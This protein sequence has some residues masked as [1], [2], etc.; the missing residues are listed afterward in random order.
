MIDI[1]YKRKKLG[2]IINFYFNK[3]KNKLNSIHLWINFN[4]P[5]GTVFSDLMPKENFCIY[6]GFFTYKCI[7]NNIKYISYGFTFFIFGITYIHGQRI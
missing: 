7:E 1:E 5:F 4:K 2:R 3:S 6:Q